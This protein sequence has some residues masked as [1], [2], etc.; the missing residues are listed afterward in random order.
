M[1]I[2][3]GKELEGYIVSRCLEIGVKHLFGLP[4]AS[5]PTT[6]DTSKYSLYCFT[7]QASMADA[8]VTETAIRE[9][10]SVI[11]SLRGVL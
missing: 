10:K 4:V 6:S 11:N 3:L 7:P 5:E 2:Q 8:A 1:R 9:T